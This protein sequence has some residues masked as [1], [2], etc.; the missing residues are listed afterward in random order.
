MKQL[1]SAIFVALLIMTGISY[2]LIPNDQIKGKISLLW[3]TDD[4]PARRVQ[5]KL[6]EHQYPQYV[7]NL[8]P[9]NGDLQKVIVQ[10]LGGVGPDI[11]DCFGQEQLTAY[12]NSGIA[13]DITDQ[14]KAKGIDA[15]SEVWPVVSDSFS[16]DGRVYGLPTN[17]SVNFMFMNKD[18]IA[19]DGVSVPKGAWTWDQ[20]IPVAQKLTHRDPATGRV[21]QWGL[22]MD[23]EN[24]PLFVYQY[25]G[26]VY[27]P[28]GTRSTLDSPQ[29]IAALQFFHD[30]IYKYKVMPSPSDVDA[31]STA[32]GFGS[33]MITLFQG[34]HSAMAFGGRWWLVNLRKDSSLHLDAAECP[35][36]KN[37]IRIFTGS[38]RSSLINAKSPRREQAPINIFAIPN[39]S[40]RHSTEP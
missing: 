16:R 30:L 17:C 11:I 4:N 37:G 10:T 27:T 25:G 21:T 24:W 34:G 36:P 35:Y 14:L 3:T 2:Y 26:S 22:L 7:C 23:W 5:I 15:K 40:T 28:D 32:G 31:M 6:F 1:F 18:L 29:D 12:V 20:F 13:W 39:T 9:S 8:D 33:G 19:K 38:S